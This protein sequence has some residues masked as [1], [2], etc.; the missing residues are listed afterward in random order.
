MLQRYRW[1][2]FILLAGTVAAINQSCYDILQTKGGF[3][4]QTCDA[5]ISPEHC[6][7]LCGLCS[8]GDISVV[9]DPV[10]FAKACQQKMQDTE[11]L[12]KFAVQ[13]IST[14]LQVQGHFWLDDLGAAEANASLCLDHLFRYMPRRDL[15]VFFS[16]PY[17]T[18][19][20]LV[21]HIRFA[22]LARATHK[23]AEAVPF[24]VFLD[25][26]LPYAVLDEPRDFAWRWRPR[27]AR[28]LAPYVADAANIT[29]AV[30]AVAA[31]LPRAELAG[32]LLVQTGGTPDFVGGPPVTWVSSVSPAMLAVSDVAQ[33]GGSCTGTGILFAAALRAVGIPARLA[34]CSESVVA[35]DDHHWVEWYDPQSAGPFGD[36]WHTKEGVSKGN[37][38]M[39]RVSAPV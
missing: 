34:G 26:V 3:G 35:G 32:L 29:A 21:E 11:T 15:L 19:D 14:A 10:D 39:C 1:W 2:I 27:L 25:S 6:F 31:V 8:A 38:G 30:H 12:L 18:L 33:H 20:F 22:L 13:T 24:P 7:L 9:A 37:E 16:S 23:W 5:S 28:L 17:A 4:D 36:F